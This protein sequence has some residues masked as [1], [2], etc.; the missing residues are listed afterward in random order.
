EQLLNELAETV[1]LA[2]FH[3]ALNGD[4]LFANERLSEILGVASITR[5]DDLAGAI[6]PEDRPAMNRA[7]KTTLAGLGDADLELRI[8]SDGP[9]YGALRLRTLVHPTG[10]LAGVIGCLEDVTESVRM[11]RR[12]EIQA[13]F[14]PLTKCYN[15]VSAMGAMSSAIAD[16]D[17]RLSAGMALVYVDLDQFKPVND[18]FGH[19]TGDQ[20]L[21]VVAERL[22]GAVRAGDVVG[23]IGGD[24]FI[25][26][27]PQVGSGPDALRIG[28]SIAAGLSG[29]T[30]I[31]GAAIPIRASIGVAW[32]D[33]VDLD[34]EQLV[35]AADG[36]MYASKRDGNCLPV[37]AEPLSS[38]TSPRHRRGQGPGPWPASSPTQDAQLVKELTQIAG[39]VDNAIG[40]ISPIGQN[41]GRI[42]RREQDDR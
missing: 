5:L 17:R 9:R 39:L 21:T 28:Q 31:H 42:Q 25:V 26:I 22:H 41:R 33:D 3:A 19:A 32:T 6:E 34:A 14:D 16:V 29:T 15:R 10:G 8:S 20:L 23:R 40:G 36:A 35:A 18:A 27:C 30:E 13:T 37:L 2:L 12:L 1:P 24:E 4:I 38:R 7:V 11:R